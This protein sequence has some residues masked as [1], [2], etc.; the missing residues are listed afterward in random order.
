MLELIVQGSENSQRVRAALLPGKSYEVGR[1]PETDLPILW[2]AH[3]SRRHVRLS[4]T[5][6]YVD[7]QRFTGATN[8]L[9]F[10]GN[11]S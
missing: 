7:V 11:E 8:P 9:F 1:A 5:A 3:I 6:E 10:A 4:A 2:D